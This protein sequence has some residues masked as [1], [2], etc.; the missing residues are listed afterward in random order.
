MSQQKFTGYGETFEA[1]LTAAT[2]AAMKSWK[3]AGPDDMARV[4]IES[5]DVLYGGIIGY[6]GTRVVTVSITGQIARMTAAEA[7]PHLSLKLDVSPDPVYANLMPPVRRPQPHK[8]AMV[9]TVSNTGNAKY[10]GQSPNS[11]FARFEVTRGRTVIWQAPEIVTQAITPIAIDPGESRTFPAEW[12]MLDAVEWVQADL[13]IAARFVPSGE[14][15]IH[16][17][18][19]QPTF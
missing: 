18:R 2:D 9:L 16:V 5:T 11:A 3:P 13:H 6:V 14:S 8:I 17:I 10:S 19:V 12:Q 1:A 15:A 4:S 7:V